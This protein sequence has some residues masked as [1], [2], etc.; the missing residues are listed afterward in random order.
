MLKVAKSLVFTSSR[1]LLFPPETVNSE[2][3]MILTKIGKYI[4]SFDTFDICHTHSV[5]QQHKMEPSKPPGQ[6]SRSDTADKRELASGS[7]SS[8]SPSPEVNVFK[9]RFRLFVIY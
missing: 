9:H 5:Q 4:D 7:P 8:L 1:L 3:H 6:K 2:K